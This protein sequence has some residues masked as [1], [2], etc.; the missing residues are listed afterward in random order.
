MQSGRRLGR[1]TE[2]WYKSAMTTLTANPSPRLYGEACVPGDKS[3]A[4]RALILSAMAEGESRLFNVPTGEDWRA[5]VGSLGELGVEIAVSGVEAVVRSPGRK[6]WCTPNADLDCGESGTTMRLLA[7]VLA[8]C[9]FTSRLTGR[10]GLL[11]R[12]MRRVAEPL[13]AMGADVELHGENAPIVLRGGPLRPIDWSTKMPSAQVKSA[14]LLA[15]LSAD[16]HTRVTE[17]A[18]SRDHTERMLA[19]LGADIRRDGLSVSVRGGWTPH[20][21]VMHM[22]GDFSAAAFLLGAAVVVPGSTVSVTGVGLN[23]TRTGFLRILEQMGAV[24]TVDQ[25]GEEAGEPVGN[26][27]VTNGPLHGCEIT[28]NLSLAALDELP[29]VA[30]LA[31]FAAGTTAIR[32]ASELRV[33]ESDR[34]QTAADGLRALGISVDLLSNGLLVHGGRLRG[35]SIDS[36]GDH[37][38]AMAFLVAGLAASGSVEVRNAECLNKSFPEFPATM[39]QLGAKLQ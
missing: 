1:L 16:G 24:V 34:L 31:A 4:H 29:L 21:F 26:V 11:R 13:Q 28:G 37:R 33:K 3:I 35:G 2:S 7:G 15:A 25:S 10:P 39:R 14:V 6:N 22:P 17:P 23:P 38:I 12:P 5:T 20:P 19:H 32:D 18:L 27:T 9:P 36:A 8:G 30:V